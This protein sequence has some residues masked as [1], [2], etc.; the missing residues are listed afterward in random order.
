MKTMQTIRSIKPIWEE[1][2][3][4]VLVE[5]RIE[6]LALIVY[7]DNVNTFTHVIECLMKYCGH[8]EIQAA[9]C[10]QLIHN[11]GKCDV[12]HG[13]YEKLKPIKEALCEAGLNAKIVE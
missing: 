3:D 2:E 12:K 9:Q 5:D 10:S 1:E 6:T 8:E 11:N 4:T 13:E 7:N